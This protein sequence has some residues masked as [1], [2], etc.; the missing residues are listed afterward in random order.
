MRKS[1]ILA[2]AIIAMPFHA[3]GQ[4]SFPKEQFSF[5]PGE[6]DVLTIHCIS[7]GSIALEIGGEI[8]YV[9]PVD[10]I[11]SG[12]YLFT[13]EHGDHLSKSTIK[14]LKELKGNDAPIFGTKNCIEAIGK[15]TVM[16]NG[17]LVT[18]L[19]GGRDVKVKAVP[20]NNT[21]KGHENF[22]PL[23]RDNGYLFE[24]GNLVVYVAGDTELIDSMSGLGKVDVAFL[25]VNQPYTMTVEQCIEAA[26]VIRPSV[27]IP[28]HLGDTDVTPIINALSGTATEVRFHEELR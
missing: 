18:I 21:T 23:G 1:L 2:V 28:Y 25:P 16:N 12:I 10:T 11:G 20:A 3:F 8:I 26:K 19:L 7:H 27:L 6:N 15:G 13:H 24:T 14:Y 22:H 5:G 4:L 9:D 17:D